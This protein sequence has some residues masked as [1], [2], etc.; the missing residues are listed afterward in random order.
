MW[1]WAAVD[2]YK[3]QGQSSAQLD[4]TLP[5]SGA[6]TYVIAIAA[7]QTLIT[8]LNDNPSATVEI[9]I[10]DPAGNI[11]NFGRGPTSLGTVATTCLLYTSRCV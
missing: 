7:G 2:V 4:G 10:T 11:V 6:A 1:M 5:A 9:T 8:D 3:R